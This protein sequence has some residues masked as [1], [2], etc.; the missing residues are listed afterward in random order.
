VAQAANLPARSAGDESNGQIRPR[1]DVQLGGGSRVNPNSDGRR[2]MRSA[3]GRR[4]GIRS[5]PLD[6]ILAFSVLHAAAAATSVSESAGQ[7]QNYDDDEEDREHG[8]LPRL[9]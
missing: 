8:H 2:W 7:Q 4:S 5:G 1:C 9:S 3:D 6:G